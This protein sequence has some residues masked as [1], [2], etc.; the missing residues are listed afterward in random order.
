[1]DGPENLAGCPKTKSLLQDLFMVNVKF[2]TGGCFL[3]DEKSR[4]QVLFAYL[5]VGGPSSR[6][7]QPEN[8]LFSLISQLAKENA[9]KTPFHTGADPCYPI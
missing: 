2:Q 6:K 9:T 3:N 7:L 8:Y 1:M 5:W 4:K